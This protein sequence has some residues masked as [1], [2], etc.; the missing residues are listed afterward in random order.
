MR[1]IFLP[2][3]LLRTVKKQSLRVQEFGVRQSFFKDRSGQFLTKHDFVF[4][5]YFE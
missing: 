2:K 1:E 3:S 4:F 5:S